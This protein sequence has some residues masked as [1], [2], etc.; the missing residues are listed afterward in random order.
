MRKSFVLTIVLLGLA[1][2]TRPA[3]DATE[4]AAASLGSY[5][6]LPGFVDMYWDDEGGRLYFSL[7]AFDEDFLYQ[8]S[9]A[10]GVGSNDLGLD[11]GQLGSTKVVSF[12]RIGPKV[13]LVQKNLNYRANSDNADEVR[14]VAESFASSVIWGFEVIGESDGAVIVDATDFLMRD[15]HGIVAYL[16]EIEEGTYEVDAS[17]SAVY[18]SRTKAFPDNSEVEAMVTFKGQPTGEILRTVVPDATSFTVHLHHSFIRLPDEN[19]EPLPYEPRAGIIG[20][21]YGMDG[22]F[23]YASEINDTLAV[24]YGRRH[25]L[26]KK[27]PSAETSEAIKPIVYYVDR[28]APEPIRSALLEGASWWNEAFTAAGYKDAFRVE[29]MTEDADPMDVRYNVIQWVHRS[30]RGWSYGSSI[31]DP[32][33]G[34][35]IKGH[36]SLGSLRVR[37]DYL[38]AEGL[39]APYVGEAKSG[40]MLDMSLARIRQL[41]AHEVGHTI[42]MEHNFAASTQG[43]TSVMDYPFPLIKFN[44]DGNLDLSDA[45]GTGMGAWD[46]RTVAYAYQD[47]PDDV[48]AI[49]GRARIMAETMASGLKYVSDEDSRAVGTAHP[50]GNLWD[51]GAD[52]LQELEHLMQVRAYAL[53]RFSERNIQPGRPLAT[54]EE[55]LVPVYLLHRFQIKAAGKLIGGDYFNYAMRGDGQRASDPVEGGRQRVAISALL[56]T[57]SPAV[58]RLPE[59]LLDAIPARPPGHQ[60]TRETFPRSTGKTFDPL[61]PARSAVTLTLDVLLN[62]ERAARMVGSHA[63]QSDLP[64]FDELLASLMGQTWYARRQNGVEAEIARLTNMQVVERLMLLANDSAATAQVRAIALDAVNG[65]DSWLAA[66]ATREDDTGWRAH[67]GFAR[68]QIQRMKDEPIDVEGRESFQAPPGSPIGSLPGW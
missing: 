14:A 61:G 31:V 48:D 65:L 54:I 51:N 19:Y 59:N 58:L 11:R 25:R 1:A 60:L 9:L 55:A 32:R 6:A 52:A 7:D 3:G 63:R 16:A 37:Q 36:V 8:S 43:R 39:L 44:T 50:D 15:S 38:I 13:L 5:E 22:F 53:G 10:R 12:Q 20:I 49:A 46:H 56:A 18:L 2:C 30:T 29:L 23:D 21:S 34:E 42:G 17:R 66:R 33:T 24:G 26:N 28:G 67:Y 41:A 57:I 27:D 40:A 4:N 45:Y 68:Y 64:G 35:I 47:F 62:P